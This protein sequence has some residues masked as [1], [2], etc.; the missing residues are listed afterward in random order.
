MLL[1]QTIRNKVMQKT[2]VNIIT[3]TLGY[4][5]PASIICDAYGYLDGC[6]LELPCFPVV[7]MFVDIA[8]YDEDY[9]FLNTETRDGIEQAGPDFEIIRITLSPDAIYI[10]LKHPA[11]HLIG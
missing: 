2:R 1:N 9:G 7:G 6:E 4:T 5:P 11:H 3:P 10:T 8:L